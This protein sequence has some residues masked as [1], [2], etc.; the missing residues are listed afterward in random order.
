MRKLGFLLVV[1][2]ASGLLGHWLIISRQVK[3]SEFMNDSLKCHMQV[4]FNQSIEKVSGRPWPRY[5]DG[6]PLEMTM[7]DD[8]CETILHLPSGRTLDLRSKS[9]AMNQDGNIVTL[10]SILP[11]PSLVDF[12]TAVKKLEEISREIGVRDAAYYE[13]I[14]A[15]LLKPAVRKPFGPKYRT[16]AN[17]ERG[18]DIFVK[19]EPNR[20]EGE[21]D[22][23]W[24]FAIDFT[25]ELEPRR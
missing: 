8:P 18:V 25:K 9:T 19:L 16:G 2:M 20:P 10:V 24:F 4:W 13:T 1:G 17:I 3:T 15:W 14:H 5:A 11:L 23:G 7:T 12:K 21:P 22:D 6:R